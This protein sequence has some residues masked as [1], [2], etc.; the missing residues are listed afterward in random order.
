[1]SQTMEPPTTITNGGPTYTLYNWTN[2]VGLELEVQKM[3]IPMYGRMLHA[4]DGS[5]TMSPYGV[6]GEVRMTSSFVLLTLL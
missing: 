3:M 1:M 5:L 2:Q 4:L 6:F